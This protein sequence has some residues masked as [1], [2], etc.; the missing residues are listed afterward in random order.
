MNKSERL[1]FNHESSSFAE[2]CGVTMEEVER[3][4]KELV[5]SLVAGD[6]ETLTAKEVRLLAVCGVLALETL[7][8]ASKGD[9]LYGLY[10]FVFALRSHKRSFHVEQFES[11]LFNPDTGDFGLGMAVNIFRLIFVEMMSTAKDVVAK[12]MLPVKLSLN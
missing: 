10:Y 9:S 6:V 3:A 1:P 12:G 11:F 7:A 8:L 5:P 4:N 2:A